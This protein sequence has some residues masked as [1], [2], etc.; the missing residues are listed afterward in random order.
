VAS[1]P[2]LIGT[3]AAGIFHPIVVIYI[4]ALNNFSDHYKVV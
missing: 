4:N 2:E 1:L 3:P